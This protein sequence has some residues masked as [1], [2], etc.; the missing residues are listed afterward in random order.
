MSQGTKIRNIQLVNHALA[1]IGL[2]WVF[3]TN[4]W[5]FLIISVLV[6]FLFCV[7]GIN[8]ALHRYLTHQSFET[9]PI[10]E[11]M[12][13]TI[14]CLC[15]LGSPL[16]WAI[17]HINHHA[18]ADRE[19]DPYSPHRLS[20]WDFL[21]TRFEPIKH[22]TSGARRL[23]RNKNVMFLQE[24]YFLPI[25]VYCT[26]L[27][28]INPWLVIFAWAIPS[29]VALYLLLIN[30][31]VCHMYG[32]KNFNTPDES[33]NNII[34]NLFTFGESWHNNHHANARNWRQG[35]KWWEFDPTSWI[36]RL[37]KK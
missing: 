32:Y 15:L 1:I 18:Y 36:I 14:S 4:Q 27:A 28:V 11:K 21:M 9:H 3:Y 20:L 25:V 22:Q 33:R 19:G 5:N 29:L 16:G 2:V 30:N 26:I 34:M 23:L 10:I 24:H 31:I 7:L 8:I 17:S 35:I 37:I 13:L 6:S 12:L